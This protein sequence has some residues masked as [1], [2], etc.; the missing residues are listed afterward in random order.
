MFSQLVVARMRNELASERG[1]TRSVKY[2]GMPI[3]PYM[4]SGSLILDSD[5][6][7]QSDESD[8]ASDEGDSIEDNEDD[9]SGDGDA[10]D[11]IGSDTDGHDMEEVV[12]LM[13]NTAHDAIIVD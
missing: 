4:P 3:L 1:I 9:G 12:D 5:D 11:G 8:V 13:P 7:D 2:N 10:S 6:S